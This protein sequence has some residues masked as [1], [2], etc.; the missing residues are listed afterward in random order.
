[1]KCHRGF[2][3]FDINLS[4]SVINIKYVTMSTTR[5]IIKMSHPLCNRVAQRT[6]RS[7]Q[8]VFHTFKNA[9]WQK[10][11]VYESNLMIITDVTFTK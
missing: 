3:T 5:P 11:Q 8:M 10:H 1:M 2:D 9:V 7:V 6:L 4:F